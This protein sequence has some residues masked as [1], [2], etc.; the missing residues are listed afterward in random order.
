MAP[1]DFYVTFNIHIADEVV[2]MGCATIGFA[3]AV[4]GIVKIVGLLVQSEKQRL[5]KD[6]RI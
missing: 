5:D 3:I 4:W 2:R 1:M 6:G